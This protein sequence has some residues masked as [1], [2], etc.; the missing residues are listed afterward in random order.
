MY[1]LVSQGIEVF[2]TDNKSEAEKILIDCNT[3]WY[4]YCQ[5]CYEN[6]ERAADNEMFLYE[7]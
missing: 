3:K 7:E 6:N 4:E 2:R 1:V 5:K